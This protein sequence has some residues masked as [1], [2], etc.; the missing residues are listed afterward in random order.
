M[1]GDIV[2]GN[3]GSPYVVTSSEMTRGRVVRVDRDCMDVEVLEHSRA[4]FVGQHY[5]SL[6]P[7]YFSL[8][9]STP[10][11]G[12]IYQINSGIEK[13]SIVRIRS[14]SDDAIK[15]KPIRGGKGLCAISRGEN[16]I[17]LNGKEVGKA[18]KKYD[19]E[20]KRTSRGA[21]AQEGDMIKVLTDNGGPVD[22]GTTWE[23]ADV[24][25]DGV[26]L[27]FGEDGCPWVCDADNYEVIGR[28]GRRLKQKEK[29]CK[30]KVG[31]TIR[32]LKYRGGCVMPGR[33]G[34]VTAVSDDYDAV[35]I[36]GTKGLVVNYRTGDYEVISSSDK[37]TYT[38]EQIAEARERVLEMVH[39]VY[40]DSGEILFFSSKD[41][42][43]Y[44]AV[45]IKN[46]VHCNLEADLGQVENPAT[47]YADDSVIGRSKCSD[48]DE[49]NEWIGKCVALCKALHKPIPSFIMGD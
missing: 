9:R 44:Y 46:G 45:L 28:V 37:H 29:P 18:I 2:K 30:A 32:I 3:D 41:K 25:E 22:A 42:K 4:C 39:D 36:D 27:L 11:V 43:T 40:A 10:E 15:V 5:M 6:D 35:T 31:D 49:P 24:C 21:K 13:G 1:V 23:V 8:V 48:N 16:L 12:E 7:Q 19:K 38:A 26:L 47:I 17:R 14:V 33:V 20:H 34:I